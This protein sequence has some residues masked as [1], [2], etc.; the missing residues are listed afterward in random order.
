MKER[1]IFRPF[2]M[3]VAPTHF[4]YFLPSDLIAKIEK[5]PRRVYKS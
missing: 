3:T 4:F 5:L 2:S 1:N